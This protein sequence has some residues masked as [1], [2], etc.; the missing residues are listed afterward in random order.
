MDMNMDMNMF[1][2]MLIMCNIFRVITSYKLHIPLS[3][4]NICDYMKYDMNKNDDNFETT[5]ID[6]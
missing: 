3:S 5:G 6:R 2:D 4:Y 1:M